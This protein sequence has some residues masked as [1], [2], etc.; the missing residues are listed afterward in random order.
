LQTSQLTKDLGGESMV[1]ER[2]FV[3]GSMSEGFVHF[4]RIKD[5]VTNST[6]ATI[7]G[8][9]YRLRVGFPVVLNIGSDSIAGQVLGLKTSELLIPLLDSFFGY[10]PQDESKSLHFRRQV[11]AQTESGAI[12]CSTYFL[13][14]EKLPKESILIENGDWRQSLKRAPALTE[15]LTDRQAQYVL[16]LGSTKGREIVP[17]DLSLYRELMNLEIIVDKGRRLALS[18]L[19]NEVFRYL[20]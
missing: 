15:Q 7:S 20:G 4:N 2:F 6:D 12:A 8:T 9:A 5:F 19:G 1:Q 10:N 11:Y 18:K 3:F 17:I 13:N 16:K 14:P